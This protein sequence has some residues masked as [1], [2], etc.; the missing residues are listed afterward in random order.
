VAMKKH[1]ANSGEKVAKELH[2]RSEAREYDRTDCRRH[3]SFMHLGSTSAISCIARIGSS[4][5][6]SCYIA[7]CSSSDAH[8][9]KLKAAREEED[10]KLAEHI[11]ANGTPVKT[12]K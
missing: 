4:L 9:L 1:E 12:K 10:R 11:A 3:D 2:A 7:V 8:A 6:V 5:S